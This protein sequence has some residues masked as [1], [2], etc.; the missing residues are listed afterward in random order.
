MKEI[1]N[2][3]LGF[4]KKAEVVVIADIDMKHEEDI[5]SL[6]LCFFTILHPPLRLSLLTS[7]CLTEKLAAVLGQDEETIDGLM[8][9]NPELYAG[10]IQQHTEALLQSGV[11]RSKIV[12]ENKKNAQEA[13]GILA[14]M[15]KNGYY[16]QKTRYHFPDSPTQKQEQEVDITSLSH[17]F[18]AM[19]EIC[20]R[21]DDTKLHEELP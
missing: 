2:V 14:S 20:K 1:T 15:L 19:S 11:E 8:R 3:K 21:W 12:L 16:I 13:S 17:A 9:Q 4:N 10:L 6:F 7:G 18:K 5:D